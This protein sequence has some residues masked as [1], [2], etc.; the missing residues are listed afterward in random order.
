MG[1]LRPAQVRR[2]TV[3]CLLPASR[4][5]ESNM[6]TVYE[7]NS[8]HQR[9]SEQVPE[10]HSSKRCMKIELQRIR[11]HWTDFCNVTSVHGVRYLA[12]SDRPLIE[13]LWW[14]S[15]LVTCLYYATVY[16]TALCKRWLD[17]PIEHTSVIKYENVIHIPLPAITFCNNMKSTSDEK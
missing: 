6:F 14:A 2:L 9:S 15:V 4:S 10:I 17:S 7:D 5:E 11:D 3:H 8:N 16:A 1:E 13:R 12:A